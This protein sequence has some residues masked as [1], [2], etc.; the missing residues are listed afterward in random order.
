MAYRL[1]LD[2]DGVL[3]DFDEGVRQATGK[4][5]GVL[6]D[7]VMWPILARTPDF[8]DR[9]PWL[10][11][12]RILWEAVKK[13]RPPILTGLPIGKWAEPQKRSWCARELGPDIEVL[14]CLARD[15]GKKALEVLEQGLTPILVDDRLKAK[16]GWEA[17]GGIFILHTS[18]KDSLEQLKA[19]GF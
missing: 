14:T 7:K 8:Y 3:A 13:Y 4:L 9:L 12:G 18:A 1:F 10:E 6:P 19:Y 5:P 17:I 2:L 15:K 11:D 16:D